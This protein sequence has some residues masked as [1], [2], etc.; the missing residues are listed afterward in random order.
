MFAFLG[1]SFDDRVW[2]DVA[3]PMLARKDSAIFSGDSLVDGWRKHVS[4]QQ[5]RRACEI[6]RLFSLDRIYSEESLPDV[7]RAHGALTAV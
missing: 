6:V 4:A 3:M 2:R 1:E 5:L 7:D